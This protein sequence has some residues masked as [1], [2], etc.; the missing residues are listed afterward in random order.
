MSVFSYARK[1][2]P[3]LGYS[4][5]LRLHSSLRLIIRKSRS[6]DKTLVLPPVLDQ[7]HGY[8]TPESPFE[9]DLHN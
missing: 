1:C 2:T 4:D 9:C 8:S 6:P 7:V 3:A 5:P